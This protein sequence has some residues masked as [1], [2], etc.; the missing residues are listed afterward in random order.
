MNKFWHFARQMLRYKRLLALAGVG[1]V[2][3]ALCAFAGLGALMWLIE[4]LFNGD[5]T[6]QQIVRQTL[7]AEGLVRYV[8]DFSHLADLLPA[9]RFLGFASILGMILVLAVMGSC[10]RFMHQ[11]FAIT[12]ALR[13]VTYIR[14]KVFERLVNL[15]MATASV[16]STS[17]NLSRVVRDTGQLTRGL[18]AVTSKAVRDALMGSVFLVTALIV[19][20]RMTALFLVGAPII[21]VTIRKFGKIIRRAAKR[22]NRQFG[23][24]IGALSEAMQSLPV[25]KAHQAEGYE[26]RR[27]HRINHAVLREEMSARTARAL[28]SPVIELIAMAG[29]MAV[30]LVA[31]WYLYRAPTPAEPKT[32]VQ[33]LI[34]LGMA[35]NSFKPLANLNNELQGA[36]AAAE[37]VDEV[38][39]MPVEPT[40]PSATDAGG[41]GRLPRHA[42]SVTFEDV[43]FT[44]PTAGRPAIAD[45]N[46]Q[47]Q[48]GTVCAIVGGNGSGKSTL[49][50]LLPRL[51]E[52]T[53]GR[54]LIDGTD[55]AGCSLRS[56]R[57][58]IAIVTQQTVL[59]EGT[60]ADNIA[61][62][63]RHV[64]RA[65]VIEAARG[66]HAHEFIDTLPEGYDSPIGEW[67]SRLS[68][69]QRQRIAIARAILRN[70]AILILDE[71]TSQIDS[72]SEAKINA[73]LA[74]FM[75]QRTTFVIAHRLS[76]V[77][78]ADLIVV[79]EDGRVASTGKHDQL[80]KASDAYRVLCRTQLHAADATAPQSTRP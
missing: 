42:R 68:G 56:V 54:V 25:V 60:I 1:A 39:C 15:P 44:Y 70:P 26:R 14:K 59:F 41:L 9:D 7:Q 6:A 30:A 31:A 36:A 63:R 75:A 43:S 37:R 77:V 10:G 69:G 57:G 34:A 3:D 55:I 21:G 76:T 20:W 40:R 61:Y 29:V 73:A 79:M 28:T 53:E 67:G 13:T 72:E 12:A 62:G 71:A 50:N 78:G 8:G 24:M 66:A 48:Q 45:V 11:Y 33:V 64:T 23:H 74:G 49:V 65:Q 38:L 5:T 22:A 16:D 32:L 17:D 52:P 58:Q 35:G 2:F 51:Y 18:T 19:D 4:Q 46:L 80:I 27:F 47:V